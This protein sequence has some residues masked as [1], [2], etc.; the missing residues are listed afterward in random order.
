MSKGRYV[1]K[2]TSSF[3]VWLLAIVLIAAVALIVFFV[4]GNGQEN[5]PSEPKNTTVGDTVNSEELNTVIETETGTVPETDGTVS[6]GNVSETEAPDNTEENPTETQE[7][8]VIVTQPTIVIQQQADAEY[9]K[10][11][12]AAMV[13]CVSMEYPDFE[14]EGIYAA[15][16]TALADK[17]DSDGAYIIFSSGGTRM[18]LHSV[19]LE[20]ERSTAGTKDISTEAMGYATFD[21]VDPASVD[22]SALMAI[23]LDELSELIAQSVLVSIYAR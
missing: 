4:N 12:A 14:L 22:T 11:L 6:I 23:E 19:A 1:K 10:W 15:S 7:P 16:A 13:V 17:F 2:K 21:L 5:I 9:E 20:A 18:A 3:P 8:V